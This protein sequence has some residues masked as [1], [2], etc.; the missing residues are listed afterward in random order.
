MES[1]QVSRL[2]AEAIP[3]YYAAAGSEEII[4]RAKPF[5]ADCF[6]VM[7]AG[8]KED[9]VSKLTEY[10]QRYGREGR[11]STV[12]GLMA[13]AEIAAT[14]NGTA[15]HAHDFDDVCTTM[16]GHPSVA[17]MP[18]VLALGEELNS[19]GEEVLR[20]YVVGVGVCALLGKLLCP[21]LNRRGWHSTQMIGAIGAA[22]AAAC[23]MKLSEEQT[24]NALGIAVSEASGV[25]SNYGTMTKPLHAGRACAKGIFAARLAADGFTSSPAAFEGSTGFI[26]AA[27]GGANLEKFAESAKNLSSEFLDPGLT[28]KPWPCCKGMHNAIWA[29]MLLLKN[30]DI[31]ADS[32]DHIDCRV[33]PFAKDM[34]IYSIAKTPLQGKFSINY[35]IAKTVL[36]GKLYMRDFEGETVDDPEV[37]EM[38]KKVNM[39]VDDEL[40]PGAGY[41][42]PSEAE[43]VDV[44][45]KDGRVFKQFCA[46]AKGTPENPMD[47]AE[48]HEKMFDCMTKLVSAEA[49][50]KLIG[51]LESLEK[52]PFITELTEYFHK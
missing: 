51:C 36:N 23:L 39:V 29:M 21:E 15:S 35:A 14:I 17:V 43:Q 13:D 7:M 27:A 37:I 41:Y 28:M 38:M 49:A 31:T 5:F 19:S 9:A 10:A 46:K 33:M 11:S 4:S 34:L 45:L 3:G 52:I 24:V 26:T 16:V 8:A 42:H 6:A 2:I 48:R 25:K 32:I 12:T 20:S 1:I 50:E 44:Y 47:T 22:A 18:A 30:G 40:V